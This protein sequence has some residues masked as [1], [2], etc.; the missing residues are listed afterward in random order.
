MPKA[1]SSSGEDGG[2]GARSTVAE[3]RVLALFIQW[4]V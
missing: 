2:V 3:G 4:D 1:T